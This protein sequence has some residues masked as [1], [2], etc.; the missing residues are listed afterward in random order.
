MQSPVTSF[1]QGLAD[2][3][4]GNDE[5]HVHTGKAPRKEA[6]ELDVEDDDRQNGDGAQAID[7]SGVMCTSG[8]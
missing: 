5:E 2:D 8:V 1:G 7:A 3:V 4:T 6:E